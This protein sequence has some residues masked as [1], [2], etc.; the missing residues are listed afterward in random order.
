[1]ASRANKQATLQMMGGK[2]NTKRAPEKMGGS[3]SKTSRKKAGYR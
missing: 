1:M 3:G 2:G